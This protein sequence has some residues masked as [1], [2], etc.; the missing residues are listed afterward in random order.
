MVQALLDTNRIMMVMM[1]IQKVC[2]QYSTVTIRDINNHHHRHHN[3]DFDEFVTQADKVQET[4]TQE[5]L[6]EAG[7][8][9]SSRWAVSSF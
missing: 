1:I 6:E 4:L 3:D 5:G 2:R 9:A 7:L 8:E